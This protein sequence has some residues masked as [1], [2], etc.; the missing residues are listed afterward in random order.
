[1]KNKKIAFTLIEILVSISIVSIISVVTLNWFLNFLEE[2]TIKL[3]TSQIINKIEELDRKIKNKEIFDYEV[4]FDKNISNSSYIV[5][6]NI[7]WEDIT[8]EISQINNNIAKLEI[9]W[10]PWNEW[11]INIYKDHKINVATTV[12]TNSYN[13]DNEVWYDYKIS[14]SLSWAINKTLNNLELKKIDKEESEIII[15]KITETIW[16]SDINKIEIKNIWGK[17]Y[18]TSSWS[19]ISEAFIYFEK[20]WA[21]SFININK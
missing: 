18:L 4:K 3:K 6:E 12:W 15:T 2:N 19:D 5:H 16:W 17:K 7:A 9:Y 21:E 11:K 13:F 8:Q 20:N 14:W 1:M 10:N